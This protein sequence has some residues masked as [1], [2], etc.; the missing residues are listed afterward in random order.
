MKFL[1]NK[2]NHELPYK[3]LKINNSERYLRA[4][5][6]DQNFEAAKKIFL[7]FTY[8]YLK[9]YDVEFSNQ[10]CILYKSKF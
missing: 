3:G 4:I 5:K 2:L 9:N 1:Q 6:T 8:I 7:D 10:S